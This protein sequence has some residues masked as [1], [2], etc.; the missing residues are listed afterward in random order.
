MAQGNEKNES[1]LDFE[2]LNWLVSKSEKEKQ[3]LIRKMMKEH[4]KLVW[5][6]DL[7]TFVLEPEDEDRA[8]K[9]RIKKIT[10]DIESYKEAI[11]NAEG[12]IIEAERELDEI[13]EACYGSSGTY[14]V[15]G[16]LSFRGC[17]LC[18]TMGAG[19]L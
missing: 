17:L 14:K 2:K 8:M 6:D 7:H 11:E 1:V 16:C 18:S 12:A 9:E 5:H 3:Q 15:V 19:Q 4:L 13:L 10:R